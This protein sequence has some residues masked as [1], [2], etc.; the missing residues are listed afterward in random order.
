M[1]GFSTAISLFQFAV[2]TL[3]YIQ[4]AREFKD[5]FETH[6][7]K[8]DI[9]QLRLSRW[10]K[11]LASLSLAIPARMRDRLLSAQGEARRLQTKLDGKSS[12]PL[13]PESCLPTDLKKIRVRFMGF[14][15]KRK[16]QAS[17]VIEGIKWVFYKK[18]HFDKFV[19]SICKLID[20]LENIIPENDREKLRELSDEE[21][22]GISKSNLEELKEVVEGC[23]PWLG[24]S[25]DEKLN[26][27][28]AGTVINQSHNTGSTVGIHNGDNKGISYGAN[29]NQLNTFN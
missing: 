25:V 14:L 3:G 16:C 9:I 5:D 18:D 12:L 11:L 21:C 23:D 7:L 20:D 1:D 2:D 15:G 29:S 26:N 22:M 28:G 24:S 13:D 8:L 17:K 10:V 4:L 6:Q 19:E 27:S